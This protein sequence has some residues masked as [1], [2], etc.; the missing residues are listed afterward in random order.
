M[1]ASSFD[2]ALGRFLS[3]SDS[4][5]IVN[6]E[7][8]EGLG[9]SMPVLGLHDGVRSHLPQINVAFGA[10]QGSRGELIHNV[11]TLYV[12]QSEQVSMQKNMLL[13][14]NANGKAHGGDRG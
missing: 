12:V 5:S 14:G 13:L 3:V 8:I 4:V 9:I 10:P 11:P 2:P 6:R 1:C 7:G